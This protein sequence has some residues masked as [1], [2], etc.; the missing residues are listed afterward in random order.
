PWIFAWSQNRLM[1]PAWLGAG[2]ALEAA[3]KRG[4]LSLL[5]EMERQWPFFNTRISMLEM[6]YAKAEPNLARYYDTCLVPEDLRHL[7]EALRGR[8]QQGIQ[9]VLELT[10]SDSL[11][12]HTPWN[13]ES[14]R[15]RNP[16]IDPLNFLQAELLAR[17]RKEQETSEQLQL[18]LMLTIAGVAAGMRNT[19]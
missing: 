5:Q 4:E 3:A 16:Y 7:G 10:R 13:R 18:A 11:M 15:L 8:L 9:A 14:V 1:L 2:E 12:S 6:V 17:S 19:G